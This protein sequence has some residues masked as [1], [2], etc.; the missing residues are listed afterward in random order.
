MMYSYGCSNQNQNETL[1]LN[2]EKKG[3]AKNTNKLSLNSIDDYTKYK[4][5][6]HSK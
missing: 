3:K 1:K 6:K 2:P 4:W 5:S